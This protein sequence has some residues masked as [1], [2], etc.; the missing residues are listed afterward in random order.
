MTGFGIFNLSNEK[1]NKPVLIIAAIIIVAP[2]ENAELS[3]SGCGSDRNDPRGQCT[4]NSGGCRFGTWREL[5]AEKTPTTT[6]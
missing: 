5:Y 2:Y 6:A 1:L 3:L 4:P